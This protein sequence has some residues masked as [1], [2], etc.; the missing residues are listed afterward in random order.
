[1]WERGNREAQP[2]P[3]PVLGDRKAEARTVERRPC[4][5]VRGWG[6]SPLP[7]RGSPGGGLW[8]GGGRGRNPADPGSPL[9]PRP[10]QWVGGGGHIGKDFGM[11]VRVWIPSRR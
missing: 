10:W 7:Q 2:L 6:R 3:S 4:Q 11:E 8:Q 1:S 5:W 9:Q